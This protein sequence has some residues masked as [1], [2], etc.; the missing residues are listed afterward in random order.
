MNTEQ[1]AAHSVSMEEQISKAHG[2]IDNCSPKA[3]GLAGVLL[4]RDN[5]EMTVCSLNAGHM[6]LLLMLQAA[7]EML[8]KLLKSE[9]QRMGLDKKDIN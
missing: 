9:I 5:E 2:L 7:Q 6:D 3:K 8:E 4:V 1:M